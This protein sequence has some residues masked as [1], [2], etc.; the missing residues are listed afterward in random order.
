M[1]IPC[2]DADYRVRCGSDADAH[3]KVRA[4]GVAFSIVW[5]LGV[6][7]FFGS[8]LFIYRVP[9]MAKI[10]IN[11]AE[12][13]AFLRFCIANARKN[14][15]ALDAAITEE[16]KI[17]HLPDDCLR[18]LLHAASSVAIDYKPVLKVHGHAHPHSHA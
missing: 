5:P 1:T 6:P 9:Q 12:R 8:L 10:K 3:A 11:K 7:L 18:V 4:A 13:V 14:N 16:C 17:E 15:M 2:T